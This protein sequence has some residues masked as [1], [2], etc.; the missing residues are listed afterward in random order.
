MAPKKPET[1]M[2]TEM[3]ADTLAEVRRSTGSTGS[4][5]TTSA[6]VN[7][8]D[9]H[10][11]AAGAFAQ[12]ILHQL[13]EF[14]H[15]ACPKVEEAV[16]WNRPVFLYRGRILCF[17]AAFAQHC[18]F[19]FW[20]AEMSGVLRAAGMPVEDASGSLG[21]LRSL[22]DLPPKEQMCDWIRHAAELA[23]AGAGKAR[24]RVARAPVE[25]PRELQDA[26]VQRPETLT[27]FG[28][29]TPGCRREYA[30]WIAEAKRP[31]T[32]TRRV[33]ETLARV[34]VGKA[35]YGDRSG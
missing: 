1:G 20:G 13:R 19:G 32:R 30:T 27:M 11:E 9:Q 28:D 23:D 17:M 8:V 34:A 6:E 18:T 15:R 10:I 2:E 12:P 21:R 5:G 3:A 33:A 35:R 16:K 24:K 26:L 22:A 14:V 4:T 7:A 31:E 29:L 25:L